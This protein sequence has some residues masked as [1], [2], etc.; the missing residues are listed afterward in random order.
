MATLRI[1]ALA[2]LVLLSACSPSK[3]DLVRSG[4]EQLETTEVIPVDV[5]MGDAASS[6]PTGL[7]FTG[8]GWIVGNDGRMDEKDTFH[9]SL[10]V[11][12]SD[13]KTIEQQIDLLPLL[14]S[15]GSVQGLAYDAAAGE[16]YF[17][18]PQIKALFS[19][20]IGT[21]TSVTKHFDLD[22]EP[23]ALALDDQGRIIL[24]RSFREK[25]GKA[26]LLTWHQKDGSQVDSM[27]IAYNPDHLFSLDGGK[28]LVSG[29]DNKKPGLLDLINVSDKTIKKAVLL[30]G[31]DAIEG[32]AAVDG[33][34][35]AVN[36]GRF[37]NDTSDLVAVYDASELIAAP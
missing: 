14:P 35:Y 15:P 2:S 4:R 18:S 27:S 16:L 22:F 5:S 37:H 36:D 30:A 29:G 34:L 28:L 17:V 11:Y 10:T 25:D 32:I 8:D 3:D 20:N 19:I 13:L 12:G 33:K 26:E 1:V 24:G 31:S 6:T 7:A 21:P 9:P 23:N